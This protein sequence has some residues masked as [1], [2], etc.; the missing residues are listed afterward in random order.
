MTGE[1]ELRGV[2][3][4]EGVNRG[5]ERVAGEKRAFAVVQIGP[6]AGR[7]GPAEMDRDTARLQVVLNCACR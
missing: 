5:R 6:R 7:R 1:V 4:G 3:L 2:R